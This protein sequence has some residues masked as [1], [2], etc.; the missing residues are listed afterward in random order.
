MD[1]LTG[2]LLMLTLFLKKNKVDKVMKNI[3]SRW[4][5]RVRKCSYCTKPGEKTAS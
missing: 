1:A 5:N 3:Q 4:E 2:N